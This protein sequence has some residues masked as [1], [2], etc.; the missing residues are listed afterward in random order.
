MMPLPGQMNAKDRGL[1]TML[2]VS[3]IFG[4]VLTVSLAGCLGPLQRN[5]ELQVY[6]PTA[7][8]RFDSLEVGEG[9]SDSVFVCLTFSG[10]GA[11]AA[12][13]AYGVLQELKNTRIPDTDPPRRLI[14]E[15][16][17]VSAVSG[18]S[19]TASAYGLWG[20]RMFDGRFQKRFLKR[21]VQRDLLLN[22]WKPRYLFRLP[23]VVLDRI[24]I[25]AEYYDMEIFEGST[26]ADLLA[27]RR[28]PFIVVNATSVALGK[29]FEFT[30][31][32]FDLLGSD[33]NSFPIGSA[34][35]ASSAFPI[36]FSPLRLKYFP[37]AP[38]RAAV[39]D[40]LLCPNGR[41][42]D[43]RRYH[44]A[45][46][47]IPAVEPGEPPRYQIDSDNHR[48]LY[49]LDGGLSDNLGVSYFF[50]SHHHGAIRRMI[51]NGNIEKLVMIIVDAKTEPPENL[52][53][54][55]S[56][57]GL[58]AVGFKTGTTSM[59]RLS[60]ALTD[61]VRYLL[62]EAPRKTRQSCEEYLSELAQRCPQAAGLQPPCSHLVDS[63]VVEVN[64]HD[65]RDQK[66]RRSFLSILTRLFL[67]G[68]EI[69]EIIA[70]GGRLLREDPEFQRLIRNLGRTQ[71][72]AP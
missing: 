43:P 1:L 65:I 56:A 69:D 29:R 48:F 60:S 49:L 59:E 21:N 41:A 23:W 58:L 13:L 61:M 12:A 70:M 8:Y 3:R 27:K 11:R 55:A 7:G 15:V 37:G 52:E 5:R 19:F 30:Q 33:L 63:Y 47:L 26:Y 46:R 6:D 14:D 40:I 44:W 22:L 2:T 39:R 64:F 50:E 31:A 72:P 10:G 32:D 17:V 45:E 18:G 67:P 16:D 71:T 36:L 57:P 66:K 9:N 34:V 51:D 68:K 4:V 35:A 28:R 24:D 25:A 54:K 38:A 62:L 42:K 20:D 53:S